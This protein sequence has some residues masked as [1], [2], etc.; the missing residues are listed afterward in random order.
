[1][2][3]T[4][5][6]QRQKNLDERLLGL[7]YVNGGLFAETLP[8]ADM[9]A[10]MRDALVRCTCFDWSRISPAVFGSLFQSIMQ[11]AERRQIGA[12]YTSERDILKLVHALFLDDLR[13][14]TQYLEGLPAKLP[15][16]PS[17][18]ESFRH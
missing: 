2:L 4:P 6:E 9:N 18:T 1:M 11:P 10:E 16:D 13:R 14:S 7:P 17:H 3:D 12:H 15:P 8:L 5:R